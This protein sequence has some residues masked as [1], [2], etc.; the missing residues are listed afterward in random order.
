MGRVSRDAKRTGG[1]SARVR[2]ATGRRRPSSGARSAWGRWA[3]SL[4]L[5]LAVAGV[6]AVLLFPRGSTPRQ[7]VEGESGVSSQPAAPVPVGTQPG[8]Q[9]PDF[10]IQTSSGDP[11]R[12]SSY[13]GQEVVL[14]FLAPG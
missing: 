4:A 5:A 10:T 11:F 7:T 2:T 14:D 8:L 3:A 13:R 9:A 12:L 6:A 1:R